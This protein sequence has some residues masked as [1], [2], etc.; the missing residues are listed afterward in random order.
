MRRWR[1]SNDQKIM[2]RAR[3]ARKERISGERERTRYNLSSQSGVS[4]EEPAGG[5]RMIRVT[6][7][8]GEVLFLNIFQIESME[9]IP[10]TKIKMMNGYYFLV[11]DSAD[12]VI[13]QIRTFIRDCTVLGGQG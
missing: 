2:D 11:K 1:R 3:D 6:R 9:S 13:E 10:E 7:L 5:K 12:S 4:Q 8:S